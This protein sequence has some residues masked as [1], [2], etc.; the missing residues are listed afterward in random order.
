MAQVAIPLAAT[1]FSVAS[2]VQKGK[3]AK[4]AASSE[5]RQMEV[6]ARRAREEGQ[7]R[8]DEEARQTAR[9]MSDA[10]AIQ[11]ASGFSASDAQALKQ[12][13]D[14]AGAG[15]YNELSHLYESEQDALTSLRGARATRKAGRRSARA[16]YL[17]AVS[18]A[19]SGAR[20]IGDGFSSWKEGS[21]RITGSSAPSGYSNPSHIATGQYRTPRF[22]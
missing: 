7:A 19:F 15:K 3:A 22:N 14:I 5:A 21:T 16:S 2:Q 11:G 17:G 18:T 13:G 10:Q 9:L 6:N 4:S 8:A 12:I 1:A 20:S